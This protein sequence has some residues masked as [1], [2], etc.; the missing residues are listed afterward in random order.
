MINP[1]A[2]VKTILKA[3]RRD[4]Y[5]RW[6]ITA[7][8]LM[9]IISVLTILL[10]IFKVTIPLF[11]QPTVEQQTAIPLPNNM[12][13][14]DVLVIGAGEYMENAFL[15]DRSGQFTLINLKTGEVDEQ[16]VLGTELEA[17][18]A[19]KHVDAF[20]ST[21]YSLLWESG[22]L[23]LISIS[24]RP[25][26]EDGIR[27]IEHRLEESYQFPAPPAEWGQTLSALG[28]MTSN[29]HFTSVRLMD[30]ATLRISQNIEEEDFLGDITEE[31]YESLI[32]EQ[33]PGT[34]SAMALSESGEVLYAGTHNGYL[35]KWKLDDP[36]NPRRVESLQAFP[37]S[38]T[39]TAM[40]MVLGDITLAVGD[41]HGRLT[42]WFPVPEKEDLALRRLHMIRELEPHDSA[43]TAIYASRRNKTIMS[44]DRSGSA[45]FDHVTSERHLYTLTGKNPL[46]NARLNLRSNGIVAVDDNNMLRTWDFDNPHPE[47]SMKTLFGKVWYENYPEPVYAWQSSSAS[48][49]FEPKF[50]LMPLIFGTLKGTVYA[51]F[52]A[53]PLSILGALYAS[54]FMNP[55]MRR[56]IK[57]TVEI[58]AAVPSVVIGF[59]AAL[60]LAPIV[61]DFFVTMLIFFTVMPVVIVALIYIL[62][63]YA[64]KRGGRL[65]GNG[66]EYIVAAPLLIAGFLISAQ[67][68]PLVEHWLFAG[69]IAQW[70]WDTFNIRYD[71][72]NSIIIS[73]A[74]GFAVIPIIFTI[75]DDALVNVPRSLVAGSLALG[76]SRW[77]TAWR[78]VLPSA[79]PGI[80]AAVMIGFGRAIGETMIV[81]MATGNTPI[82]DWGAFNGM[83]TL[84]ANIAVEIP[85]APVDGTLYRI[86]FLTAV[87]LFI[88]TFCVNTLAE[89]VRIRLRK[90]YASL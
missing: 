66:V 46:K 79:S 17:R 3:K 85:E 76:A 71:Q 28:R 80:F 47:I 81:L 31:S 63:L 32:D 73:F 78:V 23:S 41:D 82:M 67:L 84:S 74:L 61:R 72:R 40:T 9:I 13:A 51:M 21:G 48:T 2:S 70:F 56:L 34:I 62:K 53:V 7:G 54:Q 33:L 60:W 45:K 87:L 43:I 14:E 20:G 10:M 30:N 68:G 11:V 29:G 35:L 90:K 15:I 25:V 1:Q 8:G 75:T 44:L 4:R 42:T 24:F 49:D 19:L 55:R 50:S 57:P 22:A 65:P 27:T 86:L 69:D 5:A 26:F 12:E 83:R 39:I 64:E 38:R 18:G 59:L 88:A 89:I 16:K 58:M 36:G 77:Q 52:F 6:F 37:D